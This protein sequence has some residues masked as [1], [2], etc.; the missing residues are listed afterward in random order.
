M[1]IHQPT[2]RGPRKTPWLPPLAD[3]R[4]V[5]GGVALVITY[6]LRRVRENGAFRG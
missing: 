3:L 2:T 1:T 6:C 5:F 4:D